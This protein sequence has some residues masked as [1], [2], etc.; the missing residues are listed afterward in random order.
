MAQEYSF[1]V[2]SSFDRQ[3]LANAID[4][5]QREV[6]SRFDFKGVPAE[7]TLGPNEITLLTESEYKLTA[8]FDIL[9]T[10]AI[11]RNLSPKIFDP[12]KPEQAARGNMRQ[13][14]KLRQGIDDE[15]ARTLQKKIKAVSPRLQARI[16]G[17]TLRVTS[18]D[19]DTLQDVIK[20][21]KALDIPTPLQ[22][23]NYR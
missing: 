21:L 22:F 7:V 2:V 3:E 6:G 23:V 5:T 8:I 15:L 13:V 18:R 10:K 16:Q 20:E 17:D 12:G 9:S 14:I 11:K 4:Q 1:D 19:K